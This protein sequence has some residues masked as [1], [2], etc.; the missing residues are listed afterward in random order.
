MP[1]LLA[2]LAAYV[3]PQASSTTYG[4]E[5]DAKDNEPGNCMT[6]S[7]LIVYPIKSCAGIQVSS[8]VY[9]IGGLE[10]DRRWMIINQRSHAML[11]AR[12]HPK[13]R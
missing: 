13:V 2:S 1:G 10:Y 5:D 6:V 4:S 12:T 3:S 9:G 7:K 8:S 11:T